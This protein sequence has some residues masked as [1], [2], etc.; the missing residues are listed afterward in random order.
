MIIMIIKKK[1]QNNYD[2]KNKIQLKP[3]TTY[4]IYGR[5]KN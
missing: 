2:H 4:T 3:K 1:K 5:K